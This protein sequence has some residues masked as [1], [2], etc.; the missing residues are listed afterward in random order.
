MLKIFKYLAI[1]IFFISNNLLASEWEII[2][3]QE[4]EIIIGSNFPTPKSDISY[5]QNSGMKKNQLWQ[6]VNLQ[7]YPGGYLSWYKVSPGYFIYK[8]PTY[9]P[10]KRID[11]LVGEGNY[12][13][14]EKRKGF[15]NDI[16]NS[17]L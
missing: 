16:V 1:F 8:D 12:K 14:T 3:S 15:L 13:F 6:W 9:L 5:E 17:R 2:T 4:S 11:W 10:R 7:G